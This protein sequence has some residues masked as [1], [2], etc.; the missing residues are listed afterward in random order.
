MKSL[1][2]NV[3]RNLSKSLNLYV[4]SIDKRITYGAFSADNVEE[5]SGWGQLSLV[6]K[7]ELLQYMHNMQCIH[8]QFGLLGLNEQTDFRLRLPNSLVQCINE[9][10]I[11]C[12]ENQ[13]EM[14]IYQP[15]MQSIIH[16][17]KVASQ[18]LPVSERAKALDLLNKI[19]ISDNRK[20]DYSLQ[21]QK[22]FSE[23]IHIYMKTEKLQAHAKELFKKTN[24]YLQ[25]LLSPYPK[26][27]FNPQN[28]S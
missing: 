13:I 5:F 26:V 4:L 24:Y 7:S 2:F 27:Q 11:M 14:D 20:I 16:Q 25:N 23:L 1:S 12:T 28:G 10:S 21:I 3:K 15:I 18:K 8:M 9:I 6:Q 22:I 19:G 17:I